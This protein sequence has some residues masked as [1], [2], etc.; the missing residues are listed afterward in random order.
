MSITRPLKIYRIILLLLFLVNPFFLFA[1]QQDPLK[2]IIIHD[3]PVEIEKPKFLAEDESPYILPKGKTLIIYF[4]ASWCGECFQEINSLV[5][6]DKQLRKKIKDDRF[7][8]IFASVDFK[9]PKEVIE[10][11]EEYD[12]KDIK[13]VFDPKQQ[14]MKNFNILHIPTTVIINENDQEIIR[15]I[16]KTNWT[17]QNLMDFLAKNIDKTTEKKIER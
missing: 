7:E 2:S 13:I 9:K 8:I 11:L 3:E 17:K 5:E 12:I 6:L 4:F 10:F 1:K 14:N 15:S 16:K